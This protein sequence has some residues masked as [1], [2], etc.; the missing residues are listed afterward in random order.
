L[1]DGVT[2]D[3]NT[4]YLETTPDTKVLAFSKLVNSS[5]LN[6]GTTLDNNNVY[7]ETTPDTTVVDFGK[8]LTDSQS[9]SDTTG[10]NSTRTVPYADI[11]KALET[12]LL[13]NNV[14]SDTNLVTMTDTTGTGSSRTVP[15]VVL[16]KSITNTTLNYDG[17]LDDET[18]TVTGSGYLW[19]NPYTNP[20]PITSSYFS[21]DSGNY[22]EG[23]SAFTG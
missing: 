19:L 14:T 21:N 22:V 9:F 17:N 16:N 6:D 8:A 20:Y 11:S 2:A 18:V 23:E 12:H 4:V 13:Y 3:E 7:L 15:Y 1:Y 5:Y 10:T